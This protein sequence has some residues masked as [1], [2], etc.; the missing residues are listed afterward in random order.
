MIQ[1]EYNIADNL[2]ESLNRENLKQVA[3]LIDDKLHELDMLSELVSIYPR[4]DELSSNFI[5][6][7]A[8]QFHVDFYDTGLPL[9]KR[10]TLVK[11]SIRWHMRKG[12]VGVVQEVVQ[13]VFDSGVV[14]EW[15]KYSGQPYHF[16]VDLL[17][18]PE[19]TPENINLIVKCINTV[20]NVRS[21]LDGLGFRRD[22]TGIMHYGIASHMHKK[23]NIGPAQIRDASTSG[24]FYIG[25]AAH[26]HK[27][28][29]I[30]Q[31]SIND[32]YL[33][34]PYRVGVI[35][36]THKRYSI[37][38]K[39]ISDTLRRSPYKAGGGVNIYKKYQI[40]EE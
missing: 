7:L 10:R 31:V 19:I 23:I 25:G 27:R 1:A 26:M 9:E 32:T 4:I 39:S 17:S 20:K 5:D 30:E 2:P 3:Q 22:C 34:S 21:W 12:T 29:K 33:H 37:E 40:E 16:K 6:A 18:A 35:S 14:S 24:E 28:Y 11:N 36:H 15:F 13:T 8:I 38:P